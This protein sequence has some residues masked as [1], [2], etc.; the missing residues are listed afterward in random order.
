MKKNNKEENNFR[1]KSALCKTELQA[2][3]KNQ[4]DLLKS[5]KKSISKIGIT[6]I[7]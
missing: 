2:E 6:V 5:R 3:K 1:W 7:F 4:P